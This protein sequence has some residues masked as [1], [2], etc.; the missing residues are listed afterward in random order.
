M[1]L[2]QN[3]GN[4]SLRALDRRLHELW[5]TGR[6]VLL[7]WRREGRALHILHVPNALLPSAL[8][9][10]SLAEAGTHR[11]D[12]TTF[13][14][15]L[16]EGP[17]EATA[18]PLPADLAGAPGLPAI[19]DRLVGRYSVRHTASRVVALIDIVGFSLAP[20]IEQVVLLNSLAYSLSLAERRCRQLG[21]EVDAA[22]TTTG[23][24][25]YVW[26]RSEG[27]AADVALFVL[28]MLALADNA[29][30]QAAGGGLVPRLRTSFAAGSHFTFAQPDAALGEARDFIVGATTIR[31]ARMIES[32]L[33]GQILIDDL[34][35]RELDGSVRAGGRP[36]DFIRLASERLE[37]LS[38]VS[39][40]GGRVR[41][42]VTYLTGEKTAEGGF[43][44]RRYRVRDKHGFQHAAYNAKVNIHLTDGRS[45]FL[46]L[47]DAE[48]GAGEKLRQAL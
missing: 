46:G 28:M 27:A 25:C 32:A 24:G 39:L 22:R 15:L 18:L 1:P 31:L 6:N 20:Q 34:A 45:I 21:I 37:G 12:R 23:D 29:L 47:R 41:S 44:V 16:R 26:N 13:R 30:A 35:L 38:G 43:T 7:G 4:A 33:P 2:Q 11:L 40:P 17:F 5:L 14:R 3:R 42:I 8:A 48:L 19:I 36:E 9:D 10:L